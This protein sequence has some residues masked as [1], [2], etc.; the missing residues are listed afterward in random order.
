MQE[1]LAAEKT[2]ERRITSRAFVCSTVRRRRM[3][4]LLGR[5]HSSYKE[6]AICSAN[7]LP[8]QH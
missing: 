3:D 1:R 4:D 6:G 5:G 8:S 2:G 7:C